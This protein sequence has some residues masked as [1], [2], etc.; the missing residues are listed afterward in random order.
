MKRRK[1]KRYR[2]PRRNSG[3]KFIGFIGIMILA[4]VCGYLTA[5]FIIAP[6]LGYDT[7]VLK[8]D[9]PSTLTEVFKDS[10]N[11]EEKESKDN[12]EETS[13]KSYALQFGVFSSRESAEELVAKL[14]GD[15]I[16][17]EIEEADEKYKVISSII[18]TK[19]EAVKQLKDIETDQV[20]GVFITTIQ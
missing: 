17:A 11:D 7:E 15:G 9:F 14:E 4:I 1:I 5:R 8:L 20:K 6:L 12:K 13:G 2:N 16:E 18:P 10:G 3:M 19:E